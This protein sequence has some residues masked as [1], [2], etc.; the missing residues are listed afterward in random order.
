MSSRTRGQR[1]GSVR[2]YHAPRLL[3]HHFGA[4]GRQKTSIDRG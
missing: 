1:G 2:D 3:A 4:T